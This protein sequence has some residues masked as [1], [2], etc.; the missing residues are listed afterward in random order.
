M[1]DLFDIRPCLSA[2]SNSSPTGAQGAGSNE[3]VPA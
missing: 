2:A 3:P 1:L